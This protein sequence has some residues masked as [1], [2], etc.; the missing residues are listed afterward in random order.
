MKNIFCDKLFSKIIIILVMLVLSIV[1][2]I[3][4]FNSNVLFLNRNQRGIISI[5]DYNQK[6]V[7]N[8]KVIQVN[9]DKKYVNKLKIEYNSKSDIDANFEYSTLNYYN[10]KK[11][12]YKLDVFDNEVG[13]QVL[14]IKDKV[15][16]L[17]IKYNKNDNLEIKKIYIDNQVKINFFRVILIFNCFLIVM[18]L[19]YFYKS[20][21]NTQKIHKYF[22]IIGLILGTTLIILQPSA[23]YYS[24]DDQIHF[25]NTYELLGTNFNWN[26]GE[27]T[28][29]DNRGVGR[30]SISSIEEQK[31]QMKVL[32]NRDY[33]N[34]STKAGRF[35]TYNQVAYLPGA[36]A[37]NCFKLLR[38]PFSVNFK[39]TKI[40]NL[41]V[42]LLIF[43]YAIKILCLGKR[44]LT[45]I[46]LLPSSLF[47]A[48]Q[49]TYDS[50]VISGLT[51]GIVFLINWFCDN[52]SKINFKNVLIFLLSM[53]YA[54]FTKAI[55]V[56]FMLLFLFIPHEKFNSKK[57][58]L[59]IKGM[60]CVLALLI[61]ATFALPSTLLST[62]EGDL[63]GGQTNVALQFKLIISHP[64]SYIM[65]LKDNAL[66]FFSE[67]LIG[68]YSLG[69]FGYINYVSGNTYYLLLLFLSFITLTD[70]NN[71]NMKM[72][73]KFIF[74]SSII[75]TILFIWTALYLSYTPV[76]SEKINGV[77]PR[78]FI[79]LLLPFLLCFNFKNI[80]NRIPEKK[81]NVILLLFM[82]AMFMILLYSFILLKYCL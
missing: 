7:K 13:L 9:I 74:L 17:I 10:N 64:I 51:L 3:L 59:W 63:R 32:D 61:L 72:K 18:I 79:P 39:L 70:K 78:Y 62:N 73:H 42:Y 71:I 1:I 76:R 24:Y 80:S 8:E 22:F 29:I 38:I 46:G 60:I 6:I 53:M 20:G 15:N 40:I 82:S 21:G 35:I 4:F 16:K 28:M 68:A 48:C 77:Q 50:A 43:S 12:K 55:Y 19:Y 33:S 27:Y 30:D 2:E 25:K 49:F 26:I 66:K 23:T 58:E 81:Y 52:D 41:L 45:V 37:Y 69:G 31:N 47:I 75:I 36:I 5:N 56:P 57:D 14:N 54:C 11:T 67:R 65:V 34:Y 44:V